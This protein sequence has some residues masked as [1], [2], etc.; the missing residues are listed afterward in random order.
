M[1]FKFDKFIQGKTIDL[2]VATEEIAYE[3]DWYKWFNDKDINKYLIQGK[4]PNTRI[5]QRD[6]FISEL[7]KKNRLL[8]LIVTKE[9]L[10]KGVIS[11]SKIDFENNSADLALVVNDK[12][13]RKKC[14]LGAL[15]AV[16]LISQHGFDIMRL[17]R[18]YARQSRS[19][20]SWQKRME[21]LGY[22]VEGI[23]KNDFYETR[24]NFNNS[25]SI[26]CTYDDYRKIIKERGILFDSESAMLKRIK[27]MPNTSVATELEDFLNEK[28][29]E[30]Y[31]NIWSL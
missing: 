2:C 19:L 1:K 31:K 17:D 4:F 3:S 16:A 25:V 28:H 11:L 12:I 20:S 13:S 21:L 9:S 7:S 10:L 6:Y 14:L 5:Q 15:E 30:Y 27:S 24:E 22:R 18:I 8:L 23:H 26:A 29:N